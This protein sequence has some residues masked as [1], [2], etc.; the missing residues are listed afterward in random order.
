MYKINKERA[1]F[2]LFSLIFA[3]AFFFRLNDLQKY[4]FWFDEVSTRKYLPIELSFNN[5]IG[6]IKAFLAV[7]SND[8]FLPGYYILIWLYGHFFN[9]DVA[10]RMFS[11]LMGMAALIVFFHLSRCFV[12]GSQALV[13]MAVMAASPF[14]IWYAQEARGYTLV[15]FLSLVAVLVLIKAVVFKKKRWFLVFSLI[16][17]FAASSSYFALLLAGCFVAAYCWPRYVLFVNKYAGH[18]VLVGMLALLISSDWFIKIKTIE[19]WHF[20]LQPPKLY[21]FFLSPAIFTGGYSAWP[22]LILLGGGV[23]LILWFWG[24]L[25]FYREDKRSFAVMFSCSFLPLL[26]IFLISRMGLPVFLHRQLIPFAPFILICIARALFG[27]QPRFLRFLFVG[28]FS[29]YM[30]MSVLSYDQGRI[31]TGN[32]GEFY[33]GVHPRK[34]YDEILSTVSSRLRS[35]DVI[36]CADIQSMRLVRKFLQEKS[37]VKI[38]LIYSL[39]KLSPF[40]GIYFKKRFPEAGGDLEGVYMSYLGRNRGEKIDKI[41]FAYSR[42]WF[43]HSFWDSKLGD[44]PNSV[45]IIKMLEERFQL[46]EQAE[47]NG[48][49]MRLYAKNGLF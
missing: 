36:V 33:P 38:F 45:M 37:G 8:Y 20:W 41:D 6:H 3:A 21:L 34:Q 5:N 1:S 49:F 14:Y 39:L 40:D 16:A 29:V 4:P 42:V 32:D 13:A 31:Y 25:L 35:G 44:N 11:V 17:L 19:Q 23:S 12:K 7:L 46:M 43:F 47:K 18:V 30:S 24:L 9:T 15:A 28:L 10:L 27:I 48:F 26:L 22:W 2:L